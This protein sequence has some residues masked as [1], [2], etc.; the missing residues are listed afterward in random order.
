MATAGITQVS[1]LVVK[2]TFLNLKDATESESRALLRRKSDSALVCGSLAKWEPAPTPTTCLSEDEAESSWFESDDEDEVNADPCFAISEET[3]LAWPEYTPSFCLPPAKA[4]Q[5][6][7][8]SAALTQCLAPQVGH[9]ACVWPGQIACQAPTVFSSQPMGMASCGFVSIMGSSAAPVNPSTT[10]DHRATGSAGT[11]PRRSWADEPV[12]D[13]ESAPTG[14]E[15]PAQVGSALD[16]PAISMQ[17]QESLTN[18]VCSGD[19]PS[20][21][22]PSMTNSVCSDDAQSQ[23]R[24][25]KTAS[26]RSDDAASNAEDTLLPVAVFVDLSKLQRRPVRRSNRRS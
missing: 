5:P 4:Q 24:S 9:L 1:E 13:T 19:A 12:E 17:R 15:R 26:V 10:L 8:C 6:I 20:Q 7:D 2:H 3:P 23:R 25:S 14:D 22:R 11:T 21:R 18:S 16:I